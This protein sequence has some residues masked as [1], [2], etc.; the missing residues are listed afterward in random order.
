MYLFHAEMPKWLARAR[1]SDRSTCRSG[2]PPAPTS[3]SRTRC[4]PRA[5]RGPRETLAPWETPNGTCGKAVSG[6]TWFIS[7]CLSIFQGTRERPMEPFLL[8][9]IANYYGEFGEES[10]T[11]PLDRMSL[12]TNLWQW[13]ITNLFYIHLWRI[14]Y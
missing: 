8:Y 14:W 6:T 7:N 9:S 10:V 5:S 12:L 3:S 13:S 4:W 11:L 2:K 1:T